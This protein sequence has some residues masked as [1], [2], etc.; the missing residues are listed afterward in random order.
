MR[1][2]IGLLVAAVGMLAGTGIPSQWRVGECAAS[3]EQKGA[4]LARPE[5][6]LAAGTQPSQCEKVQLTV[7]P[8]LV[9]TEGG[10]PIKVNDGE[11]LIGT[12]A[13]GGKQYQLKVVFSKG[14]STDLILLSGGKRLQRRAGPPPPEVQECLRKQGVGSQGTQGWYRWVR[15]WFVLVP[16]AEA[17]YAYYF[18]VSVKLDS[19]EHYTGLVGCTTK[20]KCTVINIYEDK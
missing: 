19:G 10:P 16:E 3:D 1:L 7:P 13:L 11:H 12:A 5:I 2:R 18:I 20:I 17:G 4:G 15:D 14:R 8:N 6:R 9:E